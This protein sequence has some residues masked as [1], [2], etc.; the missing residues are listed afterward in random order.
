MTCGEA[1]I[2]EMGD[3]CCRAVCAGGAKQIFT[4]LFL[5]YVVFYILF[6]CKNTGPVLFY[7]KFTVKKNVKKM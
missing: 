1:S 4:A 2:I 5:F 6:Y 7:C 3:G